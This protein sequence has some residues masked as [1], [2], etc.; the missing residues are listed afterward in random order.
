MREVSLSLPSGIARV[1]EGAGGWA[2]PRRKRERGGER[3]RLRKNEV[4]YGRS[5]DSMIKKVWR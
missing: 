1:S 4:V 2:R 3:E 5:C